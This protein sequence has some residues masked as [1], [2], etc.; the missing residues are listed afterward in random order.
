MAMDKGLCLESARV[1]RQ[2]FSS[3]LCME[4]SS[5]VRKQ[6]AR[7]KKNDN[8]TFGEKGKISPKFHISMYTMINN[9]DSRASYF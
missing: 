8:R 5:L 6:N 9:D 2:A 7:Y 4:A 3:S 1:M